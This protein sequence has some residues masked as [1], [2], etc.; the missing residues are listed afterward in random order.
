VRYFIERESGEHRATVE[1]SNSCLY[2]LG[3][4]ATMYYT[5]LHLHVFGTV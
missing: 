2:A 4:I 5:N 3:F 1:M